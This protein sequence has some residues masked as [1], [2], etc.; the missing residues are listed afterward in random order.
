[1]ERCIVTVV[2]S[3]PFKQSRHVTGEGLRLVTKP[4]LPTPTEFSYEDT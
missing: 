3:E 2:Q 1:M 4:N